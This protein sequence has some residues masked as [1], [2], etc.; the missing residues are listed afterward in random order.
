MLL[1]GSGPAVYVGRL[2]LKRHVPNPA[3]F[4]G[5][6][7]RWGNID[8]FPDSTI[9]AITPGRPLLNVLDNGNLLRGS[10]PAVYVMQ[11]GARRHVTGPDVMSACGYTFAAVHLVNDSRLQEIPLGADLAGPPCPQVSPPGGA[12][13][14]GSDAAV[15]LMKG[16]LKRHIPDVV[17]MAAWGMRWGDVDRLAD[18]TMMGIPGGQALLD[19]LADGNLLKGDGPSIYVMDGGLRRHISSPEVMSA[20]GYY[21]SSV[22]YVAQVLGIS[23]GPD[24]NGPPCPRWIPPTGSLLKGTTDAVYIFDGAQK[25]HVASSTVFGACGYQ[26]GNVN[27]VT[28]WVLETLPT[29]APVSAQPCP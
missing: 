7:F 11:D 10:G 13:L 16:G 6:G 25:R 4:E 26:W 18:S 24:L 22:R 21:F 1:Q 8:R 3:S 17:T 5:W 14:Q 29:G 19:A 27:D 9:N 12:L 23:A 2:G 28:D 20:C 15:Y